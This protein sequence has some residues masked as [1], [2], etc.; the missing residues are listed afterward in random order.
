L[1][2]RGR[3]VVGVLAAIGVALVAG[4]LWLAMAG[5]A[6]GSSRLPGDGRPG[7][8]MH[9]VVVRPGQTLWSIAVH[10]DPAADPHV[11]IGEIVADNSLV[12]TS[13]QVGQVLWVPR[14]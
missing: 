2:R 13:V 6:Q 9:R 12:G 14:G 4:L 11:V 5:Q 10:A 3:I 1:T 7:L 8:G